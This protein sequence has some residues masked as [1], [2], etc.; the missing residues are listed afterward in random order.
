VAPEGIAATALQAWI[1]SNA[2]GGGSVEVLAA[3]FLAQDR[4]DQLLWAC[5]VNFVRGEDSFVR[6]QWAAR[7]F[8]WHIYPQD[9]GA[10]W[11]KLAAFLTRYT[12]ALDPNQAAA[13]TALWEAWNQR[14]EPAAPGVAR[15]G[16]TEAWPAFIARRSAL[17][18][19]A[20]VWSGELSRQRD[21]AA[22]L[23]DFADNVLD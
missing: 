1:A 21:L 14:G 23:V 22:Q 19:H 3:P 9:D 15:P 10:H 16:L 7:P 11:V 4:Y 18:A 20:R 6:A 12:A 8:A 13:V 5:D 2:A 17:E